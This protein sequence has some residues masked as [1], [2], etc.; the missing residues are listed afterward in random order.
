MNLLLIFIGS[1]LG[2]MLRFV[3]SSHAIF[4]F[5]TSYISGIMLVNIIGSLAIGVLAGLGFR[6]HD[7]IN[8]LLMVGFLGGFTTFSSFALEAVHI[9]A[10]GKYLDAV[11]YVLASVIFSIAGT[12]IGLKLT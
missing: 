6:N 3:I 10:S 7:I 4:K 1:G 12:I 9:S 5:E 2:G 8:P 11:L